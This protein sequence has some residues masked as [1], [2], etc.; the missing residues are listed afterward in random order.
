LAAPDLVGP[1][2]LGG[3]EFASDTRYRRLTPIQ[4][5]GTGG[6][7]RYRYPVPAAHSGTFER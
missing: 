7:L 4:I 6:S 2:Q 1:A 5:P 3:R